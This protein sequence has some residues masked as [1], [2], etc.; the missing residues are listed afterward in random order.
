[1]TAMNTR[2]TQIRKIL[3]G[4]DWNTKRSIMICH[5]FQV[6]YLELSSPQDAKTTLPQCRCPHEVLD[7]MQW[8]RRWVVDQPKKQ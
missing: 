2:Y 6:C 3:I 4:S 5:V 1:M 8:Y 7:K